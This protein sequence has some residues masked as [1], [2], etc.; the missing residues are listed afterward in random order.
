M[1]P[2]VLYL[3]KIVFGSAAG[4]LGFY[5]LLR[6]APFPIEKLTGDYSTAY[7]LDGTLPPAG[8]ICK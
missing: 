5:L 2:L 3:R 8:A 1:S 6:L 7:L 4:L